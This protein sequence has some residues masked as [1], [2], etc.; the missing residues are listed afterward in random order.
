MS[1]P[2]AWTSTWPCV[3]DSRIAV[4][5]SATSATRLMASMNGPTLTPALI[6]QSSVRR[7]R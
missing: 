5:R 2:P 6:D 4:L 3:N 7:A 1:P